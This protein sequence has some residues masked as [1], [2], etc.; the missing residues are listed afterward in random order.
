[1]SRLEITQEIWG[2]MDRI[3]DVLRKKKKKIRVE[4]IPRRGTTCSIRRRRIPLIWEE[5]EMNDLY[6][7][8]YKP[9][10]L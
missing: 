2:K 8:K 9:V 10:R 6:K 7:W 5:E 4:G 3:K 1:M